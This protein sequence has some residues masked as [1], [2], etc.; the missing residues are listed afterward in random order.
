MAL[1]FVGNASPQLSR[2]RQRAAIKDMNPKIADLSEKDA[3]YEKAAPALFGEKF[4]K[5]AKE[6]EE[7]LRC[8]NKA[9]RSGNQKFRSVPPPP[10][11]KGGGYQNNYRG[12]PQE[13]RSSRQEVGDTTRT[14]MIQSFKGKRI[15][16]E[17]NPVEQQEH[18]IVFDSL[19][20][21]YLIILS[22]NYCSDWGS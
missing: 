3:I 5:E 19:P 20:L 16:P 2:E 11:R 6:H 12:G 18:Y 9:S 14:N 22:Q 10:Q 21:I 13:H 15:L 1:Q 17:E 7:Q 8:L 4:A